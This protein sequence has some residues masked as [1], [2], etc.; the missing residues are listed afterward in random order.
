MSKTEIESEY[1]LS[2]KKKKKKSE[3]QNK[4]GRGSIIT[5]DCGS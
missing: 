1:R 4:L 2:K 5:E 3:Y